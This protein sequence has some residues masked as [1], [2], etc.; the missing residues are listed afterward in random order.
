MPDSA[1]WNARIPRLP[2]AR[3]RR[4]PRRRSRRMCH[5]C[6]IRKFAQDA[7]RFLLPDQGCARGAE[8]L[9][10]PAALQESA[11][12]R[13]NCSKRGGAVPSSGIAPD[14]CPTSDWYKLCGSRADRGDHDEGEQSMTHHRNHYV[15]AGKLSLAR[16]VSPGALRGAKAGT[17]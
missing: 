1:L 5:C 13:T 8:S 7:D 9:H 6:A 2:S 14:L 16:E 17:A 3:N 12:L 10:P 15:S 4:V 11:R